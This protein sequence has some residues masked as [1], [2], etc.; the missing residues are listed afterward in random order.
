MN[1]V[2]AGIMTSTASSEA[3]REPFERATG[4][5]PTSECLFAS[6]MKDCVCGPCSGRFQLEAFYLEVETRDSVSRDQL[7]RKLY[8]AVQATLVSYIADKGVTLA[9]CGHYRDT[10][11]GRGLY[12]VFVTM[13]A[14]CVIDW[15]VN[16]LVEKLRDLQPE[17]S[18]PPTV[19]VTG[20]GRSGDT[21]DASAFWTWLEQCMRKARPHIL[22]QD[23]V[24]FGSRENVMVNLK[25]HGFG[26]DN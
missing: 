11:P 19:D 5:E 7:E 18:P 16:T 13:T 6:P 23:A 2:M 26:D 24:R 17:G 3:R 12:S 9:L 8:D 14:E 15:L 4:T 22:P 1:A 10:T 20:Y 25:L 21:V